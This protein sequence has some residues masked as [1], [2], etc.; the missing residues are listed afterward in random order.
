MQLT[1]LSEYEQYSMTKAKLKQFE[2]QFL[3][4][5]LNYKVAEASGESEQAAT[6]HK[7]VT[8]YESAANAVREIL[9]TMPE[10]VKPTTPNRTGFPPRQ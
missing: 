5:T 7:Q 1:E 8:G 4:A 10:G 3:E 6:F 2:A 9:S